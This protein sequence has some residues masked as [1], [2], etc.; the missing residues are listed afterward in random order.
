MSEVIL[1]TGGG[2]GIGAATAILAAQRGY[3]VGVNYRQQRRQAAAAV[4]D[5]IEK[6]GGR[7]IALQADIAREDEVLRPLRRARP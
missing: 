7:A 6:K 4:V 2:R 3:A 5:E 1:I